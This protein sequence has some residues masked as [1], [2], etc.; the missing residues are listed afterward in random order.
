MVQQGK[1]ALM[2]GHPFATRL[3]FA[4]AGLREA[5]RRERSLRTQA[6]IALAAVAGALILH[7]EWIWWAALVI[8]IALVLVAEVVNS[9][10]EALAD[11]LHPTEHPSIRI[12]KDMAAG[13]VL[14]A[15]F[16]AIAVGVLMV[17]S[18]IPG[19]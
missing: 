18:R 8:V 12:A 7:V 15:T 6:T 2:K 3:Q 17:V 11:H 10:I 1:G 13:A 4:L 9:S 16:A 19:M 14:L 5:W